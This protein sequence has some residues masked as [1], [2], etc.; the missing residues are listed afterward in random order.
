MPKKVGVWIMNGKIFRRDSE[1]DSHPKI[2]TPKN[3]GD[4]DKVLSIVRG[5]RD[6]ETMNQWNAQVEN[7]YDRIHQELSKIAKF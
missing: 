3:K 5:L 1:K 7:W 2:Y 4:L 6:F